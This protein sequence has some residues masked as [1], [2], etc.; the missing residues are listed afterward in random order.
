MHGLTIASAWI[1][2]A[3]ILASVILY[4]LAGKYSM[5]ADATDADKSKAR[6][7]GMAAFWTEV[8][9]LIFV[10][11][12]AISAS[13]HPSMAKLLRGLRDRMMPSRSVV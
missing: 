5:K 1:A 4:V 7:L 6:Q 3:A 2:F 10:F 11:I 12:A 9:G 13:C 8:V